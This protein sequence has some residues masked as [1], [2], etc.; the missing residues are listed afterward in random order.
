MDRFDRL[1][2]LMQHFQMSVQPVDAGEGNL[3]VF[4][5]PETGKPSGIEFL[6]HANVTNSAKAPQ[7]RLL[8]AQA[9]WGGD[10]NPL[11]ASL[12]HR[13]VMAADGSDDTS[14]LL[15][16]VVEEASAGRCGSGSA[17]NRLCEV[18]MIRLLRREIERGAA[19]PGLLAGL[20]HVKLSRALV[21]MHD[22][23]GRRWRNSDLAE[24]AGMSLSRFSEHFVAQVGE[25][26]QS[27]LR[28]WRMI[29]ARQ[30]IAS[31]ERI[32]SV[33]RRLGYA[34]TEA[35]SRAFSRHY[36][37]CPVSFRKESRETL[38]MR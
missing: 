36:G 3:I 10:S 16:I 9:T 29:L 14:M 8:E 7:H 11:V 4:A 35:L 15:Q 34:S 37:R 32:Q 19:T 28:R 12:P 6:P 17:L 18:L 20:A 25:T 30:Q 26:P 23:P 24:I 1:S 31:G 13:L 27:Y 21:A 38:S 2:A 5:D 33:A 22:N